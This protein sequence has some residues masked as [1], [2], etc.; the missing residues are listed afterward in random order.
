MK[1]KECGA[2]LE[3]GVTICPACGKE[4]LPQSE[5]ARAQQPEQQTVQTEQPEQETTAAQP[6][7][8]TADVQPEQE[9]AVAQPEQKQPQQEGK[10]SGG[11]IALLVILA[12]AAIAVVAAL[13]VGGF[14]GSGDNGE[15]TAPTTQTTPQ[16]T[17]APTI[18]EDGNPDDV[19]CKGTYTAEG[20]ELTKQMDQVVA[21]LD[22][23]ELTNGQLQ[24]YYWMQFYDFMQT[25]GQYATMFG[26]D[27]NTPMDMQKSMDQELTWQQFFLREALNSWRNY[28]SL[29]LKAEEEGF[30][31]DAE[32]A[33]HLQELPQ[34]LEATA[35]KAGFESVEAMIQSDMGAG[36]TFADYETYM[37]DYY[38][39]FSFYGHNVDKIQVTD[40]DVEAFFEEHAQE[41]GEKGLEK[42]D[43]KT[44]DVR[45]IL[46]KP[47]GGTT[48]D[49]G[50]TTYSDEEWAACEK[51]AQEILD[52]Y[53]A[54]DQTEE[55]FAEL[56]TKHSEDPGSAS[57]GGLYTDVYEGQMVAPFEEWSFDDSR[58][59]GD[60]GLVKTDY[61]YHVMYYVDSRLVWYTTAKKDLLV[62]KGNEF[63]QSV[64]DEYPFEVDYSAIA[65]GLA[66]LTKE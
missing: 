61:G 18:P 29:T 12:V 19:T 60:Y 57:K 40:E 65:L 33:K 23:E 56:A 1:C 49:S 15:T 14:S 24:V 32:L 8:E 6:E 63:L 45:H 9:A 52:E 20:E 51:K 16:E 58:K 53:L 21:T 7:E 39:G 46:V 47:E 55:R 3:E 5:E 42:D 31:M 59:A 62:E 30:A 26:L 50:K 64:V 25:Y 2:E 43:S 34:D 38:K 41:Y 22:G 11:K 35:E 28:R 44:V 4:S 66:K 13:I 10:L 54:G 36:A 27:V 17:T 37:N 48:D